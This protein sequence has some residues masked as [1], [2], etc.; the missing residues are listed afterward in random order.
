MTLTT[1]VEVSIKMVLNCIEITVINCTIL[2]FMHLFFP[3]YCYCRCS[4]FELLFNFLLLLLNLYF[5]IENACRIFM[6][7]LT[8]ARDIHK[9]WRRRKRRRSERVLWALLPCA[10]CMFTKR[11]FLCMSISTNSASRRV[12]TWLKPFVNNYFILWSL[13]C[14]ILLLLLSAFFLVFVKSAFAIYD[15]F[16]YLK[17]YDDGSYCLDID[18]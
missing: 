16:N 12:Q 1:D 4:S 18:V 2:Y 9:R 15:K 7:N 14:N 5:L 10:F 3:P 6:L 11:F 8:R 13:L 17:F